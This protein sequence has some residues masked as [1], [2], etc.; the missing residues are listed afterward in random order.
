MR[1]HIPTGKEPESF[2][3]VRGDRG[4]WGL[5]LAG[6]F[7]ILLCP[8]SVVA[9]EGSGEAGWGWLITLGRWLNLAIL[10]GLICYFVRKP[11][12]NFFRDSRQRIHQEIRKAQEA[13]DEAQQKLE[14]IEERMR[15]LDQELAE[16]REQAEKEVEL[17]RRRLFQEA[18]KEAQR[19][20]ELARSEIDRLTR[21]TRKELKEFS[22]QLSVELAEKKIRR[23]VDEVDHRRVV[24]RFLTEMADGGRGVSS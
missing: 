2:Y 3:P 9:S 14:T 4:Q 6:F 11:L 1:T 16:V 17:E 22:A 23:E 5:V 18:N 20:L 7:L 21:L 15:S 19:V 10:F 8:N 13:R 24:E 12:G